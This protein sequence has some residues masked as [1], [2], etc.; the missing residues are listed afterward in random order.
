MC[1]YGCMDDLNR[2]IGLC[3]VLSVKLPRIQLRGVTILFQKFMFIYLNPN[4]K[5][6][7]WNAN[8]F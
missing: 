5:I 3:F 2:F 6:P 1:W 8:L 4:N 7:L